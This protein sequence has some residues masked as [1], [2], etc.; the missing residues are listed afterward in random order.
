LLSAYK[1]GEGISG[2]AVGLASRRA[3]ADFVSFHQLQL[4]FGKLRQALPLVGVTSLL[5]RFGAGGRVDTVNAV[6]LR[7]V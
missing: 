2:S 4:P 5:G 3:G 6:S 1:V 7:T